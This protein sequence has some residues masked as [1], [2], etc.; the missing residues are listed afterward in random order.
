MAVLLSSRFGVQEVIGL[1]QRIPIEVVHR[2]HTPSDDSNGDTYTLRPSNPFTV[3]SANRNRR[4]MY[5]HGNRDK[6]VVNTAFANSW[7]ARLSLIH[8]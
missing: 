6:V 5:F 2:P 1:K 3:P 4:Q 8:I 7:L